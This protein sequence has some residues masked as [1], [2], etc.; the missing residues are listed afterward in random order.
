MHGGT[1]GGAGMSGRAAIAL[2]YDDWPL[3]LDQ[4]A[5]ALLA[6]RLELRQPARR[7]PP[8]RP[9]LAAGSTIFRSDLLPL[10][11]VRLRRL[12]AAPAASPSM[13]G[14]RTVSPLPSTSRKQLRPNCALYGCLVRAGCSGARG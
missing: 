1:L 7:R 13:R 4:K 8:A 2:R 11:G 6:L 3:R 14:V 10:R 5:L 9:S 12:C